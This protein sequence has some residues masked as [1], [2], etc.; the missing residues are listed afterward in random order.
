MRVAGEDVNEPE[1]E[2]VTTRLARAATEAPVQ[3]RP[4]Y[5]HASSAPYQA[6]DQGWVGLYLRVAFGMRQERRDTR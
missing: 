5:L 1:V 6:L 4:S 2:Q 3:R